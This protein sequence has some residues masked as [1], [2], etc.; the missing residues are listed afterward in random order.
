[1]DVS[2]IIVNYNTFKLTCACIRSVIEK[3]G[4]LEHEIILIDNASA[5]VAPQQFLANFPSIKL[6]ENTENIGFAKANNQGIKLAKADFIL[7]LNSDTYFIEN[8]LD[9]MLRFIKSRSTIGIVSPILAFPNGKKQHSAQRFPSIGIVLFELFRIQKLMPSSIAEKVLLGSFFDHE[10]SISVDWV[11]G[12]CFLIRKEII[13]K[14]PECKLDEKYF[15]YGEDRQWCYDT[16]NLGYEIWHFAGTSVMHIGGASGA[17]D[18]QTLNERHKDFI[19]R[20][21]SKL[22]WCIYKLF[23]K[24]L[25]NTLKFS[26]Y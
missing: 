20:N 16:K 9:K 7:L 18:L 8:S 19:V 2:I 4:S 5:E 23:Y 24:L 17:H 26:Y 10:K 21:Y 12:T 6:I 25:T 3:T 15:M 11:W 14:L 22:C 13:N 1:M